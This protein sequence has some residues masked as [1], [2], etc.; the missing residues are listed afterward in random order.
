[1]NRIFALLS[2][3]LTLTLAPQARAG[4]AEQ[5]KGVYPILSESPNPPGLDN[6]PQPKVMVCDNDTVGNIWARWADGPLPQDL[7]PLK[8]HQSI[9]VGFNFRDTL[10]FTLEENALVGPDFMQVPGTNGKEME[11]RRR[12]D[13][14]YDV[15]VQ[16]NGLIY[17]VVGPHQPLPAALKAKNLQFR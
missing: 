5:F 4:K 3:A 10:L 17:Y 6:P 1:M 15:A 8:D 7:V 12:P 9:L 2:I 16:D 11:I 13:G 14:N